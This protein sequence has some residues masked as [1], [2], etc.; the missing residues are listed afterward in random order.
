MLG[1]CGVLGLEH[2][3]HVVTPESTAAAAESL[4]Q[5]CE[6]GLA[7]VPWGG[8]TTQGL[9]TPP[10]GCDVILST[11]GLKGIVFYTPEDLTIGVG[12]GTTLAE[13][14][15]TLNEAGQFL[16]LDVPMPER[17][18]VGGVVA[19][20]LGSVRRLRFGSVRD[21]LIGL[22][23]VLS[24]GSRCRGGGRVVKNVAGY[25]LNK[26]FTGSLGTLGVLVELNFKVQPLAP[27]HAVVRCLIP[28]LEAAL[29]CTAALAQGSSTC[30]AV[31]AEHCVGED[32]WTVVWLLEGFTGA[33]VERARGI[34]AAVEATGGVDEVAVE[35][36]AYRTEVARLA[37]ERAAAGDQGLV[38]RVSV[39]PTHVAQAVQVLLAGPAAGIRIQYVQCDMQLGVIFL[40]GSLETTASPETAAETLG[41]IRARVA[42]LQ[43]HLVLVD[44][45]V[46]LR[47]AVDPWG[48]PPAAR[49][50]AY[51][52]KRELEP[53]GL[54]NP[55]RFTYG[56]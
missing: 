33:V 53:T 51:G 7:V 55:G 5:A 43:G 44:G 4:R 29:A 39:R 8:G 20:A 48:A 28:S 19:T 37:R 21:S 40:R 45:P 49:D 9:G 25:D 14:Q 3:P 52:L 54:L 50:L 32:I 2:E 41:T 15:A 42:T 22:E 35:P 31:M 47:R 12:A 11:A 1:S 38:L 27:G 46:T 30:S 24:D 18:T 16:P 34:H 36:E 23:V 10:A 13:V 26:L 6:D 17:E 56:I